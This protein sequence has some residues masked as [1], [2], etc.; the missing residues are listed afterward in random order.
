MKFNYYKWKQKVASASP[1]NRICTMFY[2]G[3]FVSV[4]VEQV[5]I[6]CSHGHYIVF[7]TKTLRFV[8]DL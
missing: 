2:L 8:T 7:Q 6:M 5:V 4:S 3:V 1:I